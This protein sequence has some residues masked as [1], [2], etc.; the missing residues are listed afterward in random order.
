MSLFVNATV[1]INERVVHLKNGVPQRWLP[2]RDQPHY[3]WGNGN[4]VIR[5]STGPAFLRYDESM[6]DA[7]L[8]QPWFAKEVEV[9]VL[10]INERALVWQDGNI[11]S[12]LG[13]GRYV[14]LK[15]GPAVT[16]ERHEVG[17]GDFHHKHLLEILTSPTIKMTSEI[18]HVEVPAHHVG[19]MHRGGAFVRTL[20]PGT[21]GFWAGTAREQVT[22]VDLRAQRM[23]LKDQ[24]L[25][26]SD[27]VT[28]RLNV[29]VT[30]RVENPEL[31]YSSAQNS[32]EQLRGDAQLILR[33][34][35]GG[36]TLEEL[37]DRKDGVATAMTE[38]LRAMAPALG[39]S[40]SMVGVRDVIL[41]GDLREIM[42]KVLL[43][44]KEAEAN[45]IKRR[46]ETAST[47][48][49]LNTAR[50]LADHPLLMRLKE[51]EAAQ[52]MLEK[53]GSLTLYDGLNGLLGRLRMDGTSASGYVNPKPE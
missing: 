9:H 20:Q 49:Q 44:K 48:N 53:V 42:N 38:K 41:P 12:V 52:A 30:Y 31:W 34:F 22:M 11:V 36:V 35:V 43:A 27:R 32:T 4:S 45:A 21:Y 17:D 50:L 13:P 8:K 2:P 5:F 15:E 24:E 33:E 47:R 7:L 19:L 14:R 25:M 46:E 28:L 37:L 16:L 3:L 39:M 29:D 18:R 23:T 1:P 10:K 26:T 40:V 51:M 6:L